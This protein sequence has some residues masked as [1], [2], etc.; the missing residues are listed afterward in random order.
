[1][2][3]QRNVIHLR[4]TEPKPF[5]QITELVMPK[6]SKSDLVTLTSR[7]L[8]K[9]WAAI[10]KEASK[11]EPYDVIPDTGLKAAISRSIRSSTKTY[12]YVLPTQL[13]SKLADNKLDARSIQAGS[14]DPGSFDART[15]PKIRLRTIKAHAMCTSAK[16]SSTLRS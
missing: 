5:G 7:L 12:R 9:I 16:N 8:E 3:R 10:K 2:P 6:D 13:L 4:V 14:G 1:M 15:H 11:K